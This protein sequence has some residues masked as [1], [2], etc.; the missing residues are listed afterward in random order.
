[1]DWLNDNSGAINVLAFVALA[2]I[3]AFYAF[4]T[5]RLVKEQSRPYVV[6]DFELSEYSFDVLVANYG[7]RAASDIAFKVLS[8]VVFY[9]RRGDEVIRQS[10]SDLPVVKRGLEYLN[11]NRKLL[12]SFGWTHELFPKGE[13]PKDQHL[14]GVVGYRYGRAKYHGN[15][16]FDFGL[17]VHAMVYGSFYQERERLGPY[18]GDIVSG[19]RDL[20]RRR[21][22][23]LD[24]AMFVTACPICREAIG[25]G[26]KKCPKCLEWLPEPAKGIAE[27]RESREAPPTSNLQPPAS[28]SPNDG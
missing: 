26:A 21:G 24:E 25:I 1:V 19:I 20:K 11:P 27:P 3:T 10:F 9:T 17:Y 23:P 22:V 8:D 16:E 18:L 14:E 12:F 5:Y 28:G 6:V 13:V 4:W 15:F 2:V 7:N